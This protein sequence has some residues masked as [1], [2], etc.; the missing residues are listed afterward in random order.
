MSPIQLIS[1]L[2]VPFLLRSEPQTHNQLG[3]L[4]TYFNWFLVFLVAGSGSG[5][6]LFFSPG[7]LSESL[8][9]LLREKLVGNNKI[10]FLLRDEDDEDEDDEDEDDEDDEDE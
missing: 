5:C 9:S 3:K 7:K 8:K 4:D 10:F 6:V 1:K 2:V